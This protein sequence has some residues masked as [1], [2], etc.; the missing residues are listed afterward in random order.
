M[1][2]EFRQKLHLSPKN[3][4]LLETINEIIEEYAME[5]YTLTLRQLYYQLV[6][7]DVIPN[8]QSEY[9]KLSTLLVKGRMAGFVDWEAIED[10]IRVP[11]REYWVT[12]VEGAIKDTIDQYKLDRQEGQDFYIELWVEKDALS[13]VLKRV[14][15]HYHI[16]LMVNRGYSSCT[17]MHD[18]YERFVEKLAE[19][20][21]VVLLY[22]GDHDPSGLDMDR[23]IKS[24]LKEFVIN[25]DVLKEIWHEKAYDSQIH[26]LDNGFSS[27]S[28]DVQEWFY[29]QELDEK[30]SKEF[31][32]LEDP[33]HSIPMMD[34]IYAFKVF[35]ENLEVRRIGLTQEQIKK[36][37]P[38]TNPA[39]FKDPRSKDYVARFGRHSWE[40]DALNPKVL[41]SLVKSNVEGMI[42][43]N[44]FNKQLKQEE[45]GKK[46]LKKLNEIYVRE[47]KK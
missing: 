29:E 16:K 5:G 8:K 18:A 4:E 41:H 17:A 23:D 11:Y 32:N 24:R 6:S 13:G 26:N 19:G 45:K 33:S 27:L 30:E 38:P 20:K 25:S 47:F 31:Y 2:Q 34:K 36:Y 28:S 15:N 40:V 1:K 44:L 21:K 14:T 12:G 10:R 9:A 22:L 35:S 3:R 39:K 37:N 43:I 46:E 42:D 7:R